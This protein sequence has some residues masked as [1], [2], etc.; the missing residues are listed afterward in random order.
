MLEE[1]EKATRERA[2]QFRRRKGDQKQK[3]EAEIGVRSYKHVTPEYYGFA[4]PED[5]TAA[6]YEEEEKLEMAALEAAQQEWDKAHPAA[7]ATISDSSASAAASAATS[8]DDENL[9]YDSDGY[10]DR[11]QR[12]L[13]FTEHV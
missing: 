9:E 6:M 12:A 1:R 13:L 7:T 10:E 11:L 2:E 4:S 3:D 5:D 8:S